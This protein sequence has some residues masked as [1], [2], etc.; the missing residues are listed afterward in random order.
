V[1]Y[2]LF[3]GLDVVFTNR[4]VG[5]KNLFYFYNDTS[6]A[7][8]KPEDLAEYLVGVAEDLRKKKAEED[9]VRVAAVKQ[10]ID[11]EI[12][13]HLKFID[14]YMIWVN[15]VKKDRANAVAESLDRGVSTNDYFKKLWEYTAINYR[16][17]TE[18]KRVLLELKGKFEE[19]PN[20]EICKRILV[21]KADLDEAK[22]DTKETIIRSSRSYINNSDYLRMDSPKTI[23]GWRGFDKAQQR[24]VNMADIFSKQLPFLLFKQFRDTCIKWSEEIKSDHDENANYMIHSLATLVKAIKSPHEDFPDMA[25]AVMTVTDENDVEAIAAFTNILVPEEGEIIEGRQALG[26]LAQLIADY[27]YVDFQPDREEG[28]ITE[29]GGTRTIKANPLTNVETSFLINIYLNVLYGNLSE[30]DSDNFDYDYYKDLIIYINIY[31]SKFVH[32]KDRLYILYKKLSKISFLSTVIS[33]EA[34]GYEA[35]HLGKLFS[36]GRLNKFRIDENDITRLRD[37]FTTKDMLLKYLHSEFEKVEIERDEAGPVQTPNRGSTRKR[38]LNSSALN[39]PKTV[40]TRKYN[41]PNHQSHVLNL[42]I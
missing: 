10:Y 16:D 11:S 12:E 30:M 18:T 28:D 27:R 9:S 1:A 25:E 8:L 7:R 6:E 4:N 24:L 23:L 26:A 22:N 17:F 34:I 20:E 33:R 36:I 31:F 15:E 21:F 3:I 32:A 5:E 13:A 40:K 14:E 29:G 2:A 42:S 38:K 19:D 41:R 35:K 37:E 39:T